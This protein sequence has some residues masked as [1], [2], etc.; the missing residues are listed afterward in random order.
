MEKDICKVVAGIYAGKN[1]HNL[2]KEESYLVRMLEV[3]RYIIPNKPANGFVGK[4]V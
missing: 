2:T 3:C 1:L 4:A